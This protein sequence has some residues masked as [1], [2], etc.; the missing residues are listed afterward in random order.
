MYVNVFHCIKVL[1]LV[2]D[3]NECQ[4]VGNKR[5]NCSETATCTNVPGSYNCSCDAGFEGDPLVNCTG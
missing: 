5:H 1:C 3:I 4:E 2:S